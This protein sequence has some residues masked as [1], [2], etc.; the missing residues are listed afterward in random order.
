MV[1]IPL[2]FLIGTTLAW[3]Y[4]LVGNQTALY[5]YN[6]VPFLSAAAYASLPRR[7]ETQ[8]HTGGFTKHTLRGILSHS[9]NLLAPFIVFFSISLISIAV[10]YLF[11][12]KSPIPGDRQV[13]LHLV[14]PTLGS[15]VALLVRN[16]LKKQVNVFLLVLLPVI[17]TLL[18]A[19]PIF[20]F[21]YVL[22]VKGLLMALVEYLLILSL[23]LTLDNM[24]D[25]MD[26]AF[27]LAAALFTLLGLSTL[28]GLLSGFVFPYIGFD[29]NSLL[30][31]MG[32][33]SVYLLLLVFFAF[34][35]NRKGIPLSRKSAD[36]SAARATDNEAFDALCTQYQ[37]TARE[38]EVLKYLA[39]GRSTKR[40]AETLILSQETVKGH[41]KNIYRKMNTH[42][43]QQLLDIMQDA[44]FGKGETIPP[45]SG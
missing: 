13:Y 35:F 8:G 10:S 4:T 7:S 44:I 22:L 12:T 37:L 6:I 5:L 3:V 17:A 43:K 19:L 25:R 39:L 1:D 21:G 31:V 2:S 28:L 38:A 32:M 45:K 40:I 34:T 23:Y 36:E 41:T 18:L 14:A 15:L 33:F 9:R 30:L 24:S 16:T 42:S 29:G 20:G 27:V 26:D 11:L